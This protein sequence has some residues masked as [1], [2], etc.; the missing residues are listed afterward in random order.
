MNGLTKS[1]LKTLAEGLKARRERLA[2]AAREHVSRLRE[3]S[4]TS[5]GGGPAGDLA[6][7][8]LA[9]LTRDSDNAAVGRDVRELREVDAAL[10]RIADGRYGACVGCHGDIGY[11]RLA[12]YPTAVR[13]LRCQAQYERTHASPEQAPSL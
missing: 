13:C 11:D 1:Q 3:E 9:D 6:D 10:A 5:P 2:A 12:A 8:A 4:F 7:Q